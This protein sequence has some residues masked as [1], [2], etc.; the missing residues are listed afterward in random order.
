[1][2][3]S[4]VESWDDDGDFQG[5]FQAFA[6]GSTGTGPTSMSS[7]MSVRSESVAGDEDWNVV[8][9]P[10]DDHSTDQAIKSAKQAGIPLPT[11][12]PTSALLGGTIKRLG[13]KK[14]RQKIDTDW[15]NDLEM[16]DQ[17]LKLK[18]RAEEPA[19]MSGEEMDDFDDLEGSLGIRFAGTTRDGTRNRSSS[20]SVMSPSLGS[21]TA[22]SEVDEMGGL[23]LPEGP[24]DFDAILK[25]RR[26]A[27]AELSDLSQPSTTT[28]PAIEQPATMK[29][30]KKSKLVSDDNDDFLN[31]F[32]LGGGE[33]LDIRKRTNKNV[34]VKS[35]RPAP[36][37]HRP[38]TTLNFHDKPI[39]KP[40]YNRSHIPRPVSGSKQT[41][42]L[43]PVLESGAS[44]AMRERRQPTTT[45]AQ[46]LR[47]KRSMPV[48]RNHSS[49]SSFAKPPMPFL[50]PGSS[51]HSQHAPAHR[52][53][54]FHLRRDSDP[55][56]QGAQ[57]PPPRPSS[58]LANQ[59]TPDT[60]SRAP[61]QRQ[62]VAPA[63]LAREAASKRTLTKPA[64]K[65][66]FGDGSE[67]EIFDDLPTSVT[68]E[69]KFTKQPVG[70]GPPKQGLRRTQSRS[71]F[72]DPTKRNSAYS[73]VPERMMTPAP[74]KTP[75]S[76]TKGLYDNTPSYLRDTAASRIAR[77][78]R[79]AN[80]PRPRSEGP[81]QPLTTNWKAQIAARSPYTSPS[82]QRQKSKR[83]GLIS[84]IGG[85][86]VPKSEKGM[87]YNPQTFRW[88]GNENTVSSFDIPPL[89]TPTPSQHTESSYMD[90]RHGGSPS[91]PALIA[92]ISTG[93]GHNVQVQNGMVYD[94]QQ[95]KW[96]KV[97]GGRDVSGQMSPSVTDAD[98]EEDAFAGIDD[99]KDE[100]S[101][102]V[103]AGA[104]SMGVS[105]PAPGGAQG[106]SEVHEEF[107]LGPR[108]ISLQ[109]QEE[110]NWVQ[111]C[112][113]WF[114]PEGEE[115]RA[116]PDDGR[117]RWILRDM[118]PSDSLE[119]F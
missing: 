76:P 20:A 101:P 57:S 112:R 31:D 55:H 91:R 18:P 85:T 25:K 8:I 102:A 1:M 44:Q 2:A 94:P 117:W 33:V 72:R 23:E 32:D 21:A 54:P 66:N 108:F 81:L 53:M 84:G 110:E 36:A 59:V 45:S 56:R 7:R 46:L 60:P 114:V 37:A 34:Q 67:L 5:D 111:R 80:Q 19:V 42:R 97:K 10:N 89:E 106:L 9:H 103:F 68:K 22:E 27:D 90:R 93:N 4:Q 113:A 58:R 11:N 79:L 86:H 50:P 48:L 49:V 77:E 17:P 35:S 62:D 28:T 78:S 82:A 87:V 30:H 96:L 41:S 107:D 40:I 95:M 13:K 24:L 29:T 75:S 92:P 64:R 74:P 69:S 26:A 6:G 105:S 100:N 38:A 109:K 16:S 99:L 51:H 119:G 65:R 47:S 63:A 39:D 88:E 104:G 70:R 43:E 71:D 52:A 83:P 15:D 73:A 3:S 116:R 12:V 118:V 61:R 14:S 98:D 115:L